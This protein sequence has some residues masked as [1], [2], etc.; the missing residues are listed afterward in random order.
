M[1]FSPRWKF[2]IRAL[3]FPRGKA[4]PEVTREA[5]RGL[6]ALLGRL[7]EK[8]HDDRRD[9]VGHV[10]HPFG[11]R[12]GLPGDVAMH[13]LHGIGC[14]KRQSAGEHLVKRDAECVQ[15]AAGIDRTI[16]ASGLFG[17]HVG[18]GAGDGLGRLERLP[19]ACKARCN[20]ESSEFGFALGVH[21]DI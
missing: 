14:G 21:Q 10:L 2:S 13:P 5:R 17:R 3:R 1:S 20:A 11:R 16:H 4:V 8:L 19:L 18:Q 15:V 7:G 6:I 12:Y 9:G